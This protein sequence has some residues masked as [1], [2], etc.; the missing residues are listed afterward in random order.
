MKKIVILFFCQFSVLVI[1]V[2]ERWQIIFSITA[3][4][5]AVVMLYTLQESCTSSL[6]AI[7]HYR[8]T[9]HV[10]ELPLCAKTFYIFIFYFI[11]VYFDCQPY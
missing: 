1:H 11:V 3:V 2:L 10:S 6:Q 4:S 7:G 5:L 9:L 8:P